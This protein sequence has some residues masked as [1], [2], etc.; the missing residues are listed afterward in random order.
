MEIPKPL[1][2]CHLLSPMGAWGPWALLPPFPR[3]RAGAKREIP[4]RGPG[5]WGVGAAELLQAG[6]LGR[7]GGGGRS[8]GPRLEGRV[9]CTACHQREQGRGSPT[10]ATY[11]DLSP[12]AISCPLGEAFVQRD[13]WAETSTHLTP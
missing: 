13:T 7:A 5:W 3:S 9:A 11:R 1:M 12:N 6:K 4:G 8:P 10:S 2:N